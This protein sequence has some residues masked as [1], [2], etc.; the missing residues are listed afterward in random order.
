MKPRVKFTRESVFAILLAF[1]SL[2]ANASS[3]ELSRISKPL[4]IPAAPL[5]KDQIPHSKVAVGDG[6]I[7][8]A[9]LSSPTRR[10]DHGVL[11]DKTEAASLTLILGDGRKLTYE[12]PESRVF[13]DLVPRLTNLDGEDPDE[14]VIVESDVKLGASLAVY[15]LV[16]D[17][18]VKTASTQF[19]GR[20][21]RWLNPTGAGDFNGDSVPD[22][23]LVSTPHIGGTLELYSY[24]PPRLVSYAQKRG[25]ST[26]FI[27]STSLGMGTVVKGEPK[28]LI[29]APA[30]NHHELLLLE[31]VDG[32]IVER[33]SVNLPASIISELLPAGYNQWL[34]GL[35]NGSWY[36]VKAVP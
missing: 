9:Y 6:V 20:A 10:Y 2:P 33:A 17:E 11:G 36:T 28:D 23:A 35:E 1:V 34:F 12:L 30:Q 25:V 26:H 16:E 19:I 3:L 27:G 4:A 7:A 21:N 31:W 32:E 5:L 24:T 14:I 22:L 15:G 29:L 8:R 18:I 13:E